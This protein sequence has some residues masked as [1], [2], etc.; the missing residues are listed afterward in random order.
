MLIEAH[1]KPGTPVWFR[2]GLV[3]YLSEPNAALRLGK[4]FPNPADLENAMRN[5]AGEDELRQAYAAAD[6]RVAELA[7]RY[8]KQT[9]ILWVQQGLPSG[10]AEKR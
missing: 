8:G 1:V 5:P 3:L 10:V 9:L 4:S 7:R 6:A 2:E